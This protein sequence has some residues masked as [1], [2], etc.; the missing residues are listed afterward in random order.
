MSIFSQ[1]SEDGDEEVL[2]SHSSK[3]SKKEEP[4][5]KFYPKKPTKKGKVVNIIM[6]G[7]E[8]DYFIVDVD[9]NGERVPFDATLYKDVKRGDI[10]SF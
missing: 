6:R 5:K 3:D 2:P 9:G 4:Q 8:V 1:K 7:N 10:I